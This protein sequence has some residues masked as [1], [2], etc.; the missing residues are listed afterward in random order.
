MMQHRVQPS[1]AET[2][3]ITASAAVNCNPEPLVTS[4]F[5]VLG[6]FQLAFFSSDR[7]QWVVLPL[8]LL[9]LGQDHAA[10]G[11]VLG[12][13]PLSSTTGDRWRER[14][15]LRGVWRIDD[16]CGGCHVLGK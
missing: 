1:A 12:A 14:W 2:L 8:H 6:V 16:L 11:V 7:M 3:S 10:I 5:L 15:F 9:E 4:A 13:F